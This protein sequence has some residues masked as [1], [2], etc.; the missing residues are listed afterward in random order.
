MQLGGLRRRG[1][2]AFFEKHFHESC[3]MS[4]VSRYSLFLACAFACAVA[5]ACAGAC[6]PRGNIHDTKEAKSNAC[7][8]CHSAAYVQVKEPPHQGIK[9]VTCN[10]CHSTTAWVPAIG[11]GGHPEDLFP[12]QAATSKHHNPAI[13]CTDCHLA[14]LGPSTA[15]QNTDCI[16]CHI[17]AH[18]IATIDG[19]HASIAGYVPANA[20]TPH[21]CLDCHPSGAK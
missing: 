7:I 6:S 12:I 14:S 1:L 13:G 18:T 9:P 3:L 19:V 8:N 5:C 4:F 11:N 10:D 20:A 17:G 15:G 16:H 2:R 21:S